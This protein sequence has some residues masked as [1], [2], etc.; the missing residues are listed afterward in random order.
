MTKQAAQQDYKYS[1][2]KRHDDSDQDLAEGEGH[3]GFENTGEMIGG[4]R[5][6]N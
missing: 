4:D 1:L 6:I 3:E 2:I 5:D